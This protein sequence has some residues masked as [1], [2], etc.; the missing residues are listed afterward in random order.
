MKNPENVLY[1]MRSRLGLRQKHIAKA[2]GLTE[3]DISRYENGAD[4][5]FMGKCIALARF[6][7]IPA[8]AF[9]HNDLKIALSSFTGPPK[10]IRKMMK[11]MQFKRERCDEIGRR[12]EEWVYREELKK[13]RGTGHE[14]GVNPN[15]SD[16]DDAH[17]DILS[18][19]LNGGSVIIEVK[20]TNG[21]FEEPF[22]ISADELDMARECI[23]DGKNYE[24]HRVYHID[25]PKKRGQC[26]I[27]ATELFSDYEFM[28][29]TYK[30]VRK[31]KNHGWS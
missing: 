27:P 2:A 20:S 30:V 7:N 25:D 9:V 18:F 13:L 10:I 21:A 28:P 12:G 24:I 15:F 22:Y 14:N 17:F 4:N 23:K 1:Y 6:F 29:E 8:D 5:L 26:I 19:G 31:D 3:N 16:T 11:R